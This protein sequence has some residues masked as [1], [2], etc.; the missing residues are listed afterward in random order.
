MSCEKEKL[1]VDDHCGDATER[2]VYSYSAIPRVRETTTKTETTTTT[3]RADIEQETEMEMETWTTEGKQISDVPTRVEFETRPDTVIQYWTPDRD[4]IKLRRDVS[5]TIPP[6][7]HRDGGFSAKEPDLGR[8]ITEEPLTSESEHVRNYNPQHNDNILASHLT[9]RRETI[10]Q[11]PEKGDLDNFL[12]LNDTTLRG[13]TV[14]A[15]SS[16]DKTASTVSWSASPDVVA[17]FPE[18]KSRVASLNP[19]QRSC[20]PEHSASL[21]DKQEQCLVA[22]EE[23]PNEMRKDIAPSLSQLLLPN[24]SSSAAGGVAT[25]DLLRIQIETSRTSKDDSNHTSGSYT[26]Y[27]PVSLMLQREIEMQE[28]ARINRIGQDRWSTSRIFRMWRKQQRERNKLNASSS[29]TELTIHLTPEVSL[30]N[31]SRSCSPFRWKSWLTTCIRAFYNTGSLRIPDSCQG[32]DILLALEYFGIL[33]ASA[34][35]FV[36]ESALAFERIQS[37]SRYFTFRTELAETLLE[38]YDDAEEQEQQQRSVVGDDNEEDEIDYD[39]ARALFLR[40]SSK[41]RIWVLEERE[42]R[43]LA[44]PA[45]YVDGIAAKSLPV[46]TE[47]GLYGLFSE[48][49][50]NI[51]DSRNRKY[52][53]EEEEKEEDEDFQSA[54]RLPNRLRLDFCE[55]VLQSLPPRTAIHFN[56]ENVEIIPSPLHVSSRSSRFELKPVI[57]IEPAS[58]ITVHNSLTKAS[59]FESFNAGLMTEIP[60]S[61]MRSVSMGSTRSRVDPIAASKASPAGSGG[62]WKM[63]ESSTHNSPHTK[64]LAGEGI[65]PVTTDVYGNHSP[66]AQ[67]VLFLEEILHQQPQLHDEVQASQELNFRIPQR[68]MLEDP[69]SPTSIRV[70]REDT[71]QTSANALATRHREEERKAMKCMADRE[72]AP[73]TYINTELG[74]LRSVTSVLSEPVID[75]P[76]VVYGMKAAKPRLSKGMPKNDEEMVTGK[77]EDKEMLAEAARRIIQ[78]RICKGAGS[79]DRRIIEMASPPEKQPLDEQQTKPNYGASS[80]IHDSVRDAEVAPSMAEWRDV[81][82]EQEEMVYIQHGANEQH[83][84]VALDTRSTIPADD[85]FGS[86]GH[87]LASVCEAVTPAPPSNNSSSSPTRAFSVTLRNGQLVQQPMESTKEIDDQPFTGCPCRQDPSTALEEDGTSSWVPSNS[88]PDVVKEETLGEK[89]THDEFLDRARQMGIDISNQFDAFMKMAF[90]ATMDVQQ[91]SKGFLATIPEE[92]PEIS[93]AISEKPLEITTKKKPVSNDPY[94]IPKSQS[95]DSDVL[96]EASVPLPP[97]QPRRLRSKMSVARKKNSPN[98]PQ[99]IHSKKNKGY[100][101]HD[102]SVSSLSE[103]SSRRVSEQH[104]DDRKM[105]T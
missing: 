85:P 30:Q 67:K 97:H 42:E 49:K 27:L 79:S 43:L 52:D 71:G 83:R 16:P 24:T 51:E 72:A 22:Q 92:M 28:A 54:Q 89:P 66:L 32:D 21:P 76:G 14:Q 6:I 4:T 18:A 58:N 93:L 94:A 25:R 40:S 35:M 31:S 45:L 56:L 90:D 10:A 44:N 62:R 2:W 103:V 63:S 1:S 37:W 8:P 5:N 68:R 12:S 80:V 105:L 98:R 82:A 99:P 73:I 48:Q 69:T 26:F 84:D 38:A 104:R 29:T 46:R 102:Y 65:S 64:T 87:V 50:F 11:T 74:D 77:A 41:A 9:T 55:Y 78:N 17:D 23:K 39:R 7:E 20:H 47:S 88:V 15:V 91:A 33:T 86:W 57:R 96:A 70:F 100:P 60:E 95:F 3:S 75:I 36:F 34:E 53:D 59:T 19:L 61:S 13:V 81:A 101:S